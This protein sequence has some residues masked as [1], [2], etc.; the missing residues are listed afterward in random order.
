MRHFDGIPAGLIAIATGMLI[1]WVST[2]LG[3]GYGGMSLEKFAA[4]LSS[5]G[6]SFPVLALDH[7]FSGFE[8]LGVILTRRRAR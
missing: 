6:F 2:A 4:S 8:F 7:V 3:L 5:F 1:A